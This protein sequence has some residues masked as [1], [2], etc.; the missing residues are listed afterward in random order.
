MPSSAALAGGFMAPAFVAPHRGGLILVLGLL[1]FII[2]CPIFGLMAWTMGSRDL[3]EMRCGRMDRSGEG[4]T[5]AGQ[6]LGL[7]MSVLWM[8]GAVLVFGVILLAAVAGN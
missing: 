6:I 8:I 3:A 4:L 5:Q 1:G 2:S 7:I